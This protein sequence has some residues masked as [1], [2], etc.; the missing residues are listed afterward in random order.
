[1]FSNTTQYAIRSI[2]YMMN[3]P[4][5]EK[6]T[7]GE[8][9]EELNIPKPYLSK[10]LQNLAHNNIISSTKGRGGGFFLSESNLNRPLL[11]VIICTEGHN[12][13]NRCILGL[14]VC[15]DE[16][17]CILH[18]QFKAFKTN[19]EKVIENKAVKDLREIRI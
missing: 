4:D 19:V 3:L 8:M 6:H 9:A 16:N 14:D 5:K 15:S 7:V 17:P 11:D 2:I 10:V 13:F 18:Q 1:M 12:V